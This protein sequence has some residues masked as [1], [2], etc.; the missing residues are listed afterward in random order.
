[1]ADLSTFLF[2]ESLLLSL[3]SE[4]KES[5]LSEMLEHLKEDQRVVDW[6]S[7]FS[8]I[9]LPPAFPLYCNNQ[10]VAMMHHGRTNSVRDFV[11]AVGRSQKG[12]LFEN[13]QEPIHLIFVV[14]IPH[15]LNHE[16][17]RMMGA[18]A[19]VCNHCSTLEKLLLTSSFEEFVQ[20]LSQKV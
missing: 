1:M 4:N 6:K 20:L 17:L 3:S 8:S 9:L 12:I 14:A 16:Y 2:P 5:A 11:I 13:I 18:I 7:L 19:R 10:T 15:T